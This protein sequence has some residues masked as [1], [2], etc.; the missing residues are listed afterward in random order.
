M[1][2]EEYM[3][4]YQRRKAKRFKEALSI[5]DKAKRAYEEGII[6]AQTLQCV[7]EYLDL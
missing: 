6:S 7:A 5:Y 1:F 2:R 4:Q 3:I